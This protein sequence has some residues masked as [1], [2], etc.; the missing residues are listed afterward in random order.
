MKAFH[1]CSSME[2]TRNKKI[3]QIH[4]VLHKYKKLSLN[5]S[6]ELCGN[7][8]NSLRQP[9]ASVQLKI[10]T[11]EKWKGAG[12]REASVSY[13]SGTVA[14]YFLFRTIWM[15]SWKKQSCWF[16]YIIINMYTNYGPLSLF[17]NAEPLDP[18][19]QQGS[20]MRSRR[21]RREA[22]GPTCRPIYAQLWTGTKNLTSGAMDPPSDQHEC[23]RTDEPE[24]EICSNWSATWRCFS[25]IASSCGSK[26]RQKNSFVANKNSNTP[27]LWW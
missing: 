3:W 8:G 25:R 4:Q 19:L 24:P 2:H 12:V 17:R 22:G 18:S 14:T 5:Y 16:V 20:C 10:E 7:C 21:W 15:S 26:R 11:H 27:A 1:N 9:L 6:H 23:A 13:W